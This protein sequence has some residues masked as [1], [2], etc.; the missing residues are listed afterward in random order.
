MPAPV[1]GKARQG[2]ATGPRGNDIF[3]RAITYHPRAY[4]HVK[5]FFELQEQC[6]TRTHRHTDTFLVIMYVEIDPHQRVDGI[7][8]AL[9]GGHNCKLQN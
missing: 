4:F 8:F 1:Q 3:Y 5:T 9:K 6:D 2:K 7:I